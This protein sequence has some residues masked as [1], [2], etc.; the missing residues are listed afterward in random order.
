MKNL[1]NW[2]N[3][4]ENKKDPDAEIRHRGHVVFPAEDEKVNDDKDH[5]P[6]ND[7][8]QGRNALARV[9]QYSSV[10]KWYNGTLEEVKDK[11]YK[12]VHKKFPS[13]EINDDESED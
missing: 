8:N 3:F 11:V 5:F 10:P 4:N 7:K 2:E 1:L 9:N 13:I 6:I 12:L